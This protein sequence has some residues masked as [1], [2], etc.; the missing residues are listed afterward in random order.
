MVSRCPEFRRELER[1]SFDNRTFRILFKGSAISASGA[2][3]Q[4]RFRGRTSGSY[5]LANVS[6][7]QRTG[8]TLNGENG[9][10]R[11]VT[12]GGSSSTT[13][14]AGGLTSDPI[15]FNLVAG[16]NVFLTYWAPAGT[17]GV[18]RTGGTGDTAWFITGT[19]RSAT[20]DWGGLSISG[21]RAYIYGAELIIKN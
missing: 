13:V 9:T 7:V 10:S 18:Y 11:P 8:N 17:G 2:T 20:I 1:F 3:V 4:V 15:E 14:P 16:Q 21:T 19:D 5:P 12:F 6:L